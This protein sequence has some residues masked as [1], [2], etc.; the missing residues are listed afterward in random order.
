MDSSSESESDL[1]N[2]IQNYFDVSDNEDPF[3]SS[4]NTP[5]LEPSSGT[6]SP[7]LRHSIG[8][9]IQAVTFFELGIPY[10]E[11]TKKTG[12]ST[13]QLYKIRNKAISR[14]WVSGIVE[15]FH[16]EDIS[17]SG[18]PKTSQAIVDSVLKTVTQ[19]S[20]TR[21][22]SCARIAFEVSSISTTST[23]SEKTVWR[24]LCKHK[25]FS[26]KQTVKP[27]LKLADKIARLK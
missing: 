2:N 23:V 25:Y 6:S 16:V 4:S 7:Y 18:R 17:R 9:R 21:G 27:G 10:A 15:V 11:I 1:D 19:N 14:G 24:I 5:S 20:T 26:Y 12:I 3:E 22:W 13:A 8:A